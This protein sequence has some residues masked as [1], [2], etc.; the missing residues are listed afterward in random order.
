MINRRG[1]EKLTKRFIKNFHVLHTNEQIRKRIKEVSEEINN[2]YKAKTDHI[3]AIC[4]LKGAVHFYSE[5]MLNIDIDVIY[6]FVHVSS[7]SG[8]ESTGKIRVNYWIDR[9]I[10]DEYVLI[11]EDILDTGSTLSYIIKYLNR[12]SPKDLKVATLYHKVKK[13]SIK[14]DFVGFEIDDEFVLGYGLDYNEKFRNLPYVG[15]I[16]K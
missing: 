13:S 15:Y 10:T 8:S 11:V 2:Y 12:H 1:A 4:V 7:Y 14:A 9:S 5:L 16:E 3:I 6:S